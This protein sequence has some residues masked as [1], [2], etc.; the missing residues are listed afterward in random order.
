M[1]CGRSA[2]IYRERR[3]LDCL[4]KMVHLSCAGLCE[5]VRILCRSVGS[6]LSDLPRKCPILNVCVTASLTLEQAL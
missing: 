6:S 1:I 3:S 4:A 2:S 5:R